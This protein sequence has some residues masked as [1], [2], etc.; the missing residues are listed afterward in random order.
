VPDQ[1]FPQVV[2]DVQRTGSAALP[3][4][5][6]IHRAVRQAPG[7][8]SHQHVV[9]ADLGDRLVVVTAPPAPGTS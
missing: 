6:A 3:I 5:S 2:D 7:V 9:A 8:D 1:T 4:T